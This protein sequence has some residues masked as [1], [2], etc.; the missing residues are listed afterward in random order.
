MGRGMTFAFCFVCFGCFMVLQWIVRCYVQVW[1][2]LA[3]RV[4]EV[5]WFEFE[6]L[7]FYGCVSA[8][9]GCT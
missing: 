5:V 4:A 8:A 1:F 9:R 3:G 7:W 2:E 6:V